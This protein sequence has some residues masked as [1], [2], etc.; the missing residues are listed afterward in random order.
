MP[1]PAPHDSSLFFRSGASVLKPNHITRYEYPCPLKF[2]LSSLRLQSPVNASQRSRPQGRG[3][4]GIDGSVF[5]TITRAYRS[6]SD[7][8]STSARECL[9]DSRCKNP[10]G[11]AMA[12][13]T[14]YPGNTVLQSGKFK[15]RNGGLAYVIKHRTS[16]PLGHGEFGRE[17]QVYEIP[18]ET[19]RNMQPPSE[20]GHDSCK[21][22][23]EV[24][25]RVYW[26][27]QG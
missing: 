7:F 17:E 18:C 11:R 24:F 20:P 22:C 25:V 3:D 14:K 5:I 6:G 1:N 2:P 23:C 12:R 13:V 21:S 9:E 26:N 4:F 16:V 10:L 27:T 19:W 8:A 15:L